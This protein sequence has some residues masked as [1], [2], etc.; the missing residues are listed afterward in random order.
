MLAFPPRTRWIFALAAVVV[1]GGITTRVQAD[2]SSP[3][4]LD[5]HFGRLPIAFEANAGQA[6]RSVKFVAR[7]LGYTVALTP[8][9]AILALRK[10]Q[11]TEVV[12]MT[13][14]GAS[15]EPRVEGRDAL[16]GRTNYYAGNDRANWHTNIPTFAKV[17]YESVYPGVDLV[18]YGNQRQLEYDF[19]V[20]PGARPS[21]IALSFAG[22]RDMRV[23]AD[24]ALVLG[25]ARGEIRQPAPVVYQDV[26]GAR[27]S[28]AGRFVIKNKDA[29]LVAFEVGRYDTKRPLVID[30]TIGYSTYLGGAD[31][32]GATAVTVDAAGSTYVTGF[33]ISGNFPVTTS[34]CD[35]S[36]GPVYCTFVTK[37]SA[38]GTLI[39]S[40]ALAGSDGRAIAV[41]AAGNIYLS[42]GAGP[43]FSIVNGYQPFQQG[44]L[45]GYVAKLDSAGSLVYSSF[46]GG[47][48]NDIALGVAAD[49]SGHAYAVG[50]HNSA[51]GL[52][53]TAN[54]LL[55]YNPSWGCD[56][57]GATGF[58]VKV[59][60]NAVGA[61]SLDYAT[62]IAGAYNG[63]NA[64]L[65]VTVDGAGN[66]YVVGGTSSPAFP[67]TPGAFQTTFDGAPQCWVNA[68][69]YLVKLNTNPATCTPDTVN[70]TWLT[71]PESLVYGTHVGGSTD[72]FGAD[73]AID[74]TGNAYVTG[75][76]IA[77]DFPTTA[78]APQG[79]N[80]GGLDAFVVKLNATGSSLVYSTLL[81]GS[82]DD[83]ANRIAADAS[84]K[85]VVTGVTGSTAFPST[86]DALQN[87]NAGLTDAFVTRLNATGTAPLEYSSYL[88]GAADD[89]GNGVAVDGS[90]SIYVVGFTSSGNFPTTPGAMQQVASGP[91]DGFVTK[92]VIEPPTPQEVIQSVV[93]DI[94]TLPGLTPAQAG[95]ATA[96]LE[97]A[98]TSLANGNTTAASNQLNALTNQIRALIN[99]HRV[100][101]S[102]GQAVIDAVDGI[103]DQI[104]P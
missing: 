96:K 102:D 56:G 42:G 27:K 83:Y 19:I 49:A 40:T 97:A 46:I 6:D 74:A 70:G 94:A 75:G 64:A 37:I 8:T 1:A 52:Q 16:A 22:A 104:T 44:N 87:A 43:L 39:Y 103:I 95:S 66:A 38:A 30:P 3:I 17:R 10:G 69:A 67:T 54:A 18:Y 20:A 4:K 57:G 15:A 100:N 101:A 12:R 80:A 78:G 88:G 91:M 84:G 86:A 82:A 58:L 51:N 76:T 93:D 65:G 63:T 59:N 23:D 7:G 47:G 73:V 14:V 72:G 89:R 55:S 11:Q 77:T 60:T 81:G 25:L 41:D 9:E 85:V 2:N 45:D 48:G 36:S 33:T 90:G 62:N 71:C 35:Q 61:G 98:L 24:G 21:A 79:A 5:A 29:R 99:S 26:R 34:P 53:T 50:Y 32:D 28:I 68:H 13:L 31:W 92:I